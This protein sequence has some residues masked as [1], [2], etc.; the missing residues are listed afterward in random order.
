MSVYMVTRNP[1]YGNQY[2]KSFWAGEERGFDFLFKSYY[3][4][5]CFFANRYVKEIS[6]AE[7]IVS[8]AFIH[9]WAKREKIKSESHLKNYLY[10]VIFHLCLREVEK[11]KVKGY[12]QIENETP[13]VQCLDKNA[14]ENIIRAELLSE[15]YLSINSLPK[16]CRR[17][18]NKLYLEGKTVKEIATELNLSVSTV[19]TQKAR[20][21]QFLRSRLSPRSLLLL[22]LSF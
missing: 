12:V 11:I 5:L 22:L 14:L 7:D 4:S 17:I 8:D 16:E 3:K 6:A 9:L 10:K 20:A 15:I 2:M 1:E 18:F 13:E 19:K 21:L